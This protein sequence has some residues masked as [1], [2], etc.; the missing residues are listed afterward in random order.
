MGYPMKRRFFII[1][2]CLFLVFFH[3]TMMIISMIMLN[4]RIAAVREKCLAEHYVI[5][6]AM[7][8]DIQ[9]VESRSVAIENAIEGLMRPYSYYTQNRKMSL[10]VFHNGEQ[11]YCSGNHFSPNTTEDRIDS[12]A[13]ENVSGYLT[14]PSFSETVSEKIK[15]NKE[16]DTRFV[17]MEKDAE[18]LHIYGNL[19]AP[20]QE[21]GLLYT[22]GLEDVMTEWRRTKSV[23]FFVAAAAVFILA[24]F[25]YFLLEF[26]FKPLQEISRSSRTI[27]DGAY[28]TRLKVSGRDEI[29]E[30]ADNFNRMAKQVETHIALLKEEA[31]KKQQF[32]DNFAHELRTP[33]AAVYGYAEYMQKTQISEKER[34]ECT[35]TIMEQCKRLQNM[36]YQL[37]ELATLQETSE[38]TG[39]RMEQCSIQE[40]F[41]QSKETMQIK[42]MEKDISLHFF[43]G[44]V[45]EAGEKVCHERNPGKEEMTVTGCFDLLVSLLNNLID[46][47]IKASQEGSAIIVSGFL[48]EEKQEKV[49]LEISDEGIGMKEEE[50]SHVKE[51]FYRADKARSRAMGGAGLGLSI[52]EQI[53]T[54]HKG[55]LQLISAP[56]KGTTVRVS[57]P[58][59]L[60]V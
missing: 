34:I 28:H 45:T 53:V 1:L 10:S 25:L 37:M 6:S 42:A 31:V 22:S 36:A 27:A 38:I 35:Q 23:L 20:Y 24:L 29:A 9:A 56:E 47:A 55:Q 7:L 59:H 14:E 43:I 8:V 32:I 40:L 12:E 46:N 17:F 2:F 18:R 54:L 15:Q 57:F 51:A 58:K 3:T 30:M 16:S 19:P 39:L 44:D 13:F 33:L 52:C 4:D 60:Q 11:I 41:R 50:L 49:V 48:T 5:S 26:C 21:Y